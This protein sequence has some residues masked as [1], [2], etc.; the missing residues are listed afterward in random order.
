MQSA[1]NNFI[2]D[3]S[4][5]GRAGTAVLRFVRG[6]VRAGTAW[7]LSCSTG[8][9]SVCHLSVRLTVCLPFLS[10]RSVSLCSFLAYFMNYSTLALV[11]DE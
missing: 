11:D 1:S 10:S 2:A 9:P 6:H 3:L 4:Q 7:E 5:A 8:C